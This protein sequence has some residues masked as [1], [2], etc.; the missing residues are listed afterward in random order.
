MHSGQVRLCLDGETLVV[1]LAVE[2]FRF[3]LPKTPACRSMVA[4]SQYA[5]QF[6]FPFHGAKSRHEKHLVS[7]AYLRELANFRLNSKNPCSAGVWNPDLPPKFT[8]KEL[9]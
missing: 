4:F 6:L 5:N 2:V 3:S 1:S 9:T 7:R 8:H